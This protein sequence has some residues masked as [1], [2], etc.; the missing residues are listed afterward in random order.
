MIPS[1][2]RRQAR[3][4]AA[5]EE[6]EEAEDVGAAEVAL[7]FLDGVDVD[8]RRRDVGA[9]PVERQ[10]RRREG[11]LLADVGDAEGV[12]NRPEHY[13]SRVWQE[14]PAASIF[15]LA[16]ALKACART[17]SFFEISPR[18]RILTGSE[19][20]ARPFS[21]RRLRRH[22]GAG[23]EA[24]LEVGEVDRLGLGAEVL[25]RHRLLHVRAAQLSHPHVDRVL[26][27]L[28]AGLALAPER[29]PAPLWPRPEVLPRPRA[30]A[31]ADPLA[32]PCASRAS[33]SGCAA[34]S[35]RS[36][37]RL[38]HQPSSTSTRCET[39]RS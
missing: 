37:A 20:L 38:S 21:F 28:V 15:S 35:P 12:G 26:P 9:E 32:R 29:E 36:A 11:E 2:K 27:A 3:E 6:V 22:L 10:H 8:A 24:L 31:A 14:P 19:R 1:A 25:E 4:A 5:R 34:R 7:D 23:V 33:A 13:G 39:T 30:L 17:V 18:A 16:A